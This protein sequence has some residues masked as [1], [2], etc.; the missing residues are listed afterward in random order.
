[1]WKWIYV[2]LPIIQFTTL[3]ATGF[4]WIW[5]NLSQTIINNPE[6]PHHYANIIKRSNIEKKTQSLLGFWI[7]SNYMLIYFIL[8][9]LL[10]LPT[11]I[12]WNLTDGNP[13]L[14]CKVCY[15]DVYLKNN[16]QVFKSINPNKLIACIII[17]TQINKRT[18]PIT[19][20]SNY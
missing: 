1:M 20:S 5:L 8:S 13:Y 9:F 18:Q 14:L 3:V 15:F 10:Y 12:A 4:W 6:R 7:F 2:L 17:L 16:G 11:I 19:T